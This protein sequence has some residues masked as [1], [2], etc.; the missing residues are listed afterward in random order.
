M[1][2]YN[3]KRNTSTTT[4][5]PHAKRFRRQECAQPISARFATNIDE[6]FEDFM[7]HDQL[8]VVP[9]YATPSCDDEKKRQE[10]EQQQTGLGTVS[11]AQEYEVIKEERVYTWQSSNKGARKLR[12]GG[13]PSNVHKRKYSG[14]NIC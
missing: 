4:D 3:R 12:Y 1:E 2:K 8:T 13:L 5:E 10:T 11:I 6:M 14:I 7:L 9:V